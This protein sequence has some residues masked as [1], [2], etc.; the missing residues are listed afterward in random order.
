MA[1]FLLNGWGSAGS[2]QSTLPA[3]TRPGLHPQHHVT[4][5]WWHTPSPSTRGRDSRIGRLDHP[6]LQSEASLGYVKQKQNTKWE[7]GRV[8]VKTSGWEI[9][10]C[11]VKLRTDTRTHLATEKLKCAE[12]QRPPEERWDAHWCGRCKRR[13][14][15]VHSENFL[16]T[17]KRSHDWKQKRYRSQ[18]IIGPKAGASE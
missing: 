6:L 5:V 17:N 11:D 4:Q 12:G 15:K 3:C 13:I 10:N 1:I 9:S 14:H 8:R 7:L 16:Q 2:G 18:K